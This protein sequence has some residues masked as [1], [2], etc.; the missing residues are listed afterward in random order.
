MNALMSRVLTAAVIGCG[1]MGADFGGV[2]QSGLPPGWLP[3]DHAGALA[4]CEGIALESLCD[5]QRDRLEDAAK[6]FGVGRLYESASDLLRESRP[7]LVAIAT[8]TPGRSELIEACLAAG[9]RGLHVEKPLGR[10]VAEVRRVLARV[11]EAGAVLS[12]GTNRRG[13]AAYRQARA[14]VHDGAIG[15]I[16][17][18]S[19]EHGQNLLLWGHPHSMDLI[20]FFA[21]SMDV[22]WVQASCEISSQ[23]LDE[24]RLDCDPAL[25]SAFVQFQD[26][27]SATISQGGGLNVRI[28]GDSGVLAVESDG[29]RVELRTRVGSR[30][31]FSHSRTIPID[32]TDSGTL[33]CMKRL[34]NAVGASGVPLFRPEEIELGMRLLLACAWSS[35]EDGRRVDPTSIPDDFVVTG[36][37]RE[38]YA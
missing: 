21:G 19:I 4:G 17:H 28:T 18:I 25:L 27:T 22:A 36:R 26:G 9:V 8:R 31:Y 33:Y 6:R 20:L 24:R 5:P 15:S 38:L 11:R 29:V 3:N 23:D 13:V 14:L 34:R 16:R 12:Y 1:R 2:S 7:D 32:A 30:P 37:L 10:S 35:I